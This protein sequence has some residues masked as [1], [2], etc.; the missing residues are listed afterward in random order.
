MESKVDKVICFQIGKTSKAKN[1][2][3]DFKV[4]TPENPLIS[5]QAI[6]SK[7]ISV[8]Y[9]N[10]Q[11]NSYP[12]TQ[13]DL[14]HSDNLSFWIYGSQYMINQSMHRSK[15]M[16]NHQL[17]KD[18]GCKVIQFI[19]TMK[20]T[21]LLGYKT[22]RRTKTVASSRERWTRENLSPVTICLNK[23]FVSSFIKCD[24]P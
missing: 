16:T 9:T 12:N 2:P 24:G 23:T 11:L 20:T 17:E 22:L 15:Y 18:I 14:Y 6:T 13:L 7:G 10:L 21:K 19:N 1:L 4:T 3:S 5:Q 8:P